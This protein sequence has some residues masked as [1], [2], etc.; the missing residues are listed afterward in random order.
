MYIIFDV[1][2]V[3]MMTYKFMN[4]WLVKIKDIDKIKKAIQIDRVTALEK[5]YVYGWAIR[6]EMNSGLDYKEAVKQLRYVC[7]DIFIEEINC[8]AIMKAGTKYLVLD[9]SILCETE[10]LVIK[11]D[12]YYQLYDLLQGKF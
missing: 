7:G 9:I 12:D 11:P 10:E 6:A 2:E 1:M 5:L 8:F 3:M 4:G